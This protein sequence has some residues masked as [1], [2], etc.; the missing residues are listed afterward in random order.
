[1]FRFV[2]VFDG[3]CGGGGG[4]FSLSCQVRKGGIHTITALEDKDMEEGI[5]TIWV[6]LVVEGSIGNERHLSSGNMTLL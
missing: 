3:S 6:D 2:I 4:Y 1:M 5:Q